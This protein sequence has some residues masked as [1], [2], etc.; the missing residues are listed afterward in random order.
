M[1]CMIS[2]K[3]VNAI[4]QK[5]QPEDIQA[6][7]KEIPDDES[8]QATILRVRKISPVLC[9]IFSFISSFFSFAEFYFCANSFEHGKQELFAL[10]RCHRQ[11]SS[12]VEGELH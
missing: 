4:K 12:H 8:D 7:L 6:I 11:V 5:C 1:T 10:F 3:L 9:T 2:A